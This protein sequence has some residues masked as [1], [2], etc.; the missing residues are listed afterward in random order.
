SITT[1]HTSAAS[2][3]G[4]AM[5]VLPAAMRQYVGTLTCAMWQ[6]FWHNAKREA[7]FI[8]RDA[9]HDTLR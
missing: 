7:P 2:N 3:T 6:Q 4:T 9:S 8:Q 1:G 5:S